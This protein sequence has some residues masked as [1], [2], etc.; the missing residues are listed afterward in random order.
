MRLMT[1]LAVAAIVSAGCAAPSTVSA[2]GTTSPSTS[3]HESASALSEPPSQPSSEP[4]GKSCSGFAIS[5]ARAAKGKPTAA[6]AVTAWLA[7]RP[8][9]F[10]PDPA[11][12][13]R[14]G[15]AQSDSV[16]YVSGTAHV[17]VS[18]LHAPGSGW[19]ITAGVNCP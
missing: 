17:T 10:N 6:R 9:G 15:P 12:W 18:H 3:T 7:G 16:R 19:I 5:I 4:S 11:T 1:A 14:A 13:H 2:G 8:E